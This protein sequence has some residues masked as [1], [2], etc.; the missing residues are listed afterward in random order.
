MSNVTVYSVAELKKLERQKLE[1][2]FLNHILWAQLPQPI[3]EYKFHPKRKWRADFAWPDQMVV[4]ECQGGTW[5]KGAH[6]RGRGYDNDCRKH[7]AAVLL[8]WKVLWVTTSMLENDPAGIMEQLGELL[9]VKPYEPAKKL[10]PL[11]GI[12]K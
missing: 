10:R 1:T 5:S 4:I 7:N 11:K 12:E 9:E 2:A 3:R 6:V 8:G